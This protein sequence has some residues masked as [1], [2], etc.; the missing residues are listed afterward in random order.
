MAGSHPGVAE[1][2]LRVLLQLAA[3]RAVLGDQERPARPGLREHRLD[4]LLDVGRG[5]G[6]ASRRRPWPVARPRP[7]STSPPP[8]KVAAYEDRACEGGGLADAGGSAL[9][10][11]PPEEQGRERQHRSQHRFATVTAA[12][13]LVRGRPHAVPRPGALAR[14]YGTTP[15]RSLSGSLFGLAMDLGISSSAGRFI[16]ERRGDRRAIADYVADALRLKVADRRGSSALVLF[17]ARR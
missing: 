9:P 13:A 7:G 12:L 2:P 1:V 3:T 5:C 15:S 16:A 14:G 8:P 4:R 10:P 6:S 11:P 17:F